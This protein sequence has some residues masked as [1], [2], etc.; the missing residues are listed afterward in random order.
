MSNNKYWQSLEQFEETP[1]FKEQANKE[2]IEELPVFDYVDDATKVES[3]GRRDFLKMMGISFSA[4]AIVSSCKIPVNKAVPYVFNLDQSSRIPELMPGVADYFASSYAEGGDFMSVLVKTRENRPIKI[5]GNTAAP[6]S[7]GGTTGRAQASVLGLYDITRLTQPKKKGDSITWEQADTE[8]ANKLASIATS[9]GKIVVLTNTNYSLATK[10]ALEVFKAKYPTT[11]VVTYDPIS[12]YAIRKANQTT[13]GSAIIPTYLFD[14]AQVIAGFNCDFLGAWVNTTENARRYITNRVPSKENPNMSRHY[15]FQSNVTITG[16]KADYKYAIKPSQEKAVLIALYNKLAGTTLASVNIGELQAGVDKLAAELLANKGASIV[17]SG[18]NNV[19]IQLLTNAING[20]LGNYGSTIDTT[21]ALNLKQG[22][23]EALK[24]LS[25]DTSVKAILLVGANPVY[26]SAFS[27]K[28]K[29]II[30]KAELSVSFAD[31]VDESAELVQYIT[32]DSHYLESWD[33]LEPKKGFIAFVQ[34]TINPL[35]DTRQAAVSLIEF[36]GDTTTAHDLAQSVGLPFTTNFPTLL[37]NTAWESALQAGFVASLNEVATGA[38]NVSA[39]IA[40]INTTLPTSKGLE[41]VVFESI[42]LGDGKYSNNPY[43]LEMPDPITRVSWDNYIALPYTFAI[44]NGIQ[45]MSQ[46]STVKTAKVTV[47]GKEII[48]PVV[49]SYGQAQDTIAIALGFGRSEGVG[50]AAFGAG[51]NAYPL[52]KFDNGTISYA[53]DGVT[54][55]T[56]NETRKIGLSQRYHTLQEDSNLPGRPRRY[57]SNIVKEANLTDYRKSDSAGNE[58]RA[59]IKEHLTTL[60][61]SYDSLGHHWSMAVDLNA[62]IGCGACVISCNVE[63]N[64]PV[65]GRKEMS[66]TRSMHWMRI[67]RYY[68]GDPDNPDVAF[69]PLMCQHCD[70]A[71]CENV[72]PV[73]ATSH[74]SEGLNQMAYNRC[75]GTKYCA[76]NCPFKVRKFNWYD[77]QGG[78]AFGAWND[79]TDATY[80][81]NDLTRMV[82]NPD[83]TVRSRGVM[84]KCTFCV[85]RIQ[86]AKLTAK[87]D[88]RKLKDGEI[89]TACQTACPTGAITFGD[90]NDKNSEIH[91]IFYDS[92]RNY[93][94]Y[95]EQHFLPNVGYQVKI[96]NTDEKPNFTFI[97]ALE[98]KA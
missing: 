34:P 61:K 30:S 70:N 84:E 91:H 80:M 50:Q 37:G 89:Q 55:E 17:V 2:F 68:S 47:N 14:K 27:E 13:L 54:Y 78:D 86:S 58:D 35:F 52:I 21:A 12:L 77:Y 98:E 28:F 19:D 56:L 45:A 94:L 22:N 71:P 16:S 32:P 74:S 4:A 38:A 23:D 73:N 57:R 69:Q 76:N 67:D 60:Y 46:A 63:N 88:G 26:D 97:G 72:C 3:T 66:N 51:E 11:E 82:L 85:Q 79:H 43:L 62:C 75:I 7:K 44:N 48:L 18:T 92:G 25:D 65:I 20:L 5:E 49:I 36:A 33:V 59:S 6:L 42:P 90:R 40:A 41:L 93:H 9:G 87:S 1:E 24:A 53:V 31:R 81:L 15:Q 29:N 64:I 95:E 10:K 8:I 83:V 96:R 39:T